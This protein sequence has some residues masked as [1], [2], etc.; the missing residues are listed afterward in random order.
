MKKKGVYSLIYLMAFAVLILSVSAF[1]PH[2]FAA[3]NKKDEKKKT[4]EEKNEG[5]GDISKTS[6]YNLCKEVG[7]MPGSEIDLTV[8]PARTTEVSCSIGDTGFACFLDSSG[9][10]VSDCYAWRPRD[11]ETA[12]SSLLIPPHLLRDQ[13]DFR[14]AQPMPLIVPP[15]TPKPEPMPIPPT[16][17]PPPAEPA[18]QAP[19]SSSSQPTSKPEHPMHPVKP[20][21]PIIP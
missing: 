11:N 20:P 7:G 15:N 19:S 13:R 9:E 10:T 8:S 5:E 17:P 12:Q 4:E 16:S 14:K 18:V 21:Q 3:E 1:S 6:F 2:G